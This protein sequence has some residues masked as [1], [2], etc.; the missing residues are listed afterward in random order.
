M[1]FH[2]LQLGFEVGGVALHSEKYD[3][4]LIRFPNNPWSAEKAELVGEKQ[5][6]GLA[7]VVPIHIE[8]DPVHHS[9]A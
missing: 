2:Q 1:L 5:G 9:V 3:F 6:T 4:H 8:G 7:Q